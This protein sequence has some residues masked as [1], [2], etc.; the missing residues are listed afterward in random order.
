MLATYDW[1]SQEIH[2]NCHVM[3]NGVPG[4]SVVRF[5]PWARGHEASDDD[6]AVAFYF[7]GKK[8]AS[9]SNLDIAGT[10]GNVDASVSHY[11]VFGKID[12][13]SLFLLQRCPAVRCRNVRRT[14]R[15]LR[16]PDWRAAL[17]FA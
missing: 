15:R 6:L 14:D 16:Y 3:R 4:V 8:M 2:L 10:P 1:F 5:G 11:G 9:Y 17:D 7:N 13:I 12:R